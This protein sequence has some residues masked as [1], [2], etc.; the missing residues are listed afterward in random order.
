VQRSGVLHIE[1]MES[2]LDNILLARQGST[3]PVGE[4]TKFLEVTCQVDDGDTV[5]VEG[6]TD[7]IGRDDVIYVRNAWR[8]EPVPNGEPAV[9]PVSV[10]ESTPVATPVLKKPALR[11][12]KRSGM[13]VTAEPGSVV[14]ASAKK[15]VAVAAGVAA[16]VKAAVKT[17]PVTA[18]KKTG[19]K[20]APVAPKKA[21]AGKAVARKA[22]SPKKIAA[23]KPAAKKAGATRSSKKNLAKKAAPKRGGMRKLRFKNNKAKTLRGKVGRGRK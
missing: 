5:T 15:F 12:S 22:E 8:I 16:G 9:A 18:Q 4:A 17:A 10:T 3:N 14:T 2:R 1:G 6:I 7:K 20:P 21:V 13:P 11:S 19:G 23:S